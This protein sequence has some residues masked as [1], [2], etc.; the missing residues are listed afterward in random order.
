MKNRKTLLA[1]AGV[2]ALLFTGAYILYARWM[3]DFV[4]NWSDDLVV[5]S[6]HLLGVCIPLALASLA[7]GAIMREGWHFYKAM[8]EP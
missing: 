7:E 8:T 3:V 6:L 2:A 5:N 1:L 4:L